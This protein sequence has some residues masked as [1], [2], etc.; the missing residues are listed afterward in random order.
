M[1]KILETWL[2]DYIDPVFDIYRVLHSAA[3]GCS[4]LLTEGAF[5]A[6]A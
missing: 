2:A 5:R 6:M 4:S 1:L 3:Q